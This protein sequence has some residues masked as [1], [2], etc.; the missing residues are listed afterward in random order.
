VC[1]KEGLC[2][3]LAGSLSILALRFLELAR[4]HRLKPVPQ[5]WAP[6]DEFEVADVKLGHYN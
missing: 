6:R 1:R 5:E 3:L 2:R 4:L